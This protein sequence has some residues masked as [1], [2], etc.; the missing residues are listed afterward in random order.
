MN[1]SVDSL[2][3]GC[4]PGT[5]VLINKFD[6]QS[7]EELDAVEGT[8]VPAKSALWAQNPQAETF[9]FAHYCALHRYLLRIFTL[10]PAQSER[11]I[12]PKSVRSSARPT[13]YQRW[14]RL[15]SGGWPHTARLFDPTAQHAGYRLDFTCVYPDDLMIATIQ[16]AG[17]VDDVLCQLF[18]GMVT[19]R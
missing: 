5:T 6:L 15:F 12:F 10:G 13:G 9:D 11:W 1:Y 8:L 14:H 3:D 7:Q 18:A 4:Y 16:A 17:G 19:P 2:T